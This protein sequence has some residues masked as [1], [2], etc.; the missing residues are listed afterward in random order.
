M[1]LKEILKQSFDEPKE[2][3]LQRYKAAKFIFVLTS[4]LFF[5]NFYFVGVNFYVDIFSK[6]LGISY[7]LLLLSLVFYIYFLIKH[8]FIEKIPKYLFVLIPVLFFASFIILL[9]PVIFRW[10]FFWIFELL[11][12]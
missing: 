7:I 12:I 11:G 10:W 6:T 9:L 3:S 4:F 8:I 2:I 1:S 5:V